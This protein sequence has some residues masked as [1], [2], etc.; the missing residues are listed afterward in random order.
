MSKPQEPELR[1]SERTS[2]TDTNPEKERNVSGQPHGTDKGGKG[3]GRGSGKGD[4]RPPEQRPPH[5]S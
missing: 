3:G 5:P 4:P 2:P 1:R